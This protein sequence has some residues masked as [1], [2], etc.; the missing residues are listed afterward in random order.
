M[1][2][3]N[4]HHLLYFWTVAREG[5][6]ARASERLRLAQPTISGQ[7]R[8]LER[9]L[10]HKL[11]VKKGRGLALTEFGRMVYRHADEIFRLGGELMEA[12]KGRPSGQPLR[13]TVGIADVMPKLVTYRL[14]EPAIRLPE[15][16]RIVC[17]EDRPER[18]LADLAVHELDIVLADAPIPPSV[19]VRA[20]NHLLGECGVSVLATREI[21]VRH[22]KGFPKSLDGAP[23][24]LPLEGTALR[25]SLDQWLDAHEI[26]PRIIAECDDSALIKA[27]GQAG[28]GL[29]VA[30]DVIEEEVRRQYGVRV[31]GRVPEVRE[32]FYAI[33]VERRLKH[34]AVVAI[35]EAARSATFL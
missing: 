27:F 19:K 18:L 20:Y 12:V 9:S 15:P 3:L 25:R 16:V 29:F 6:V 2:W 8:A 22:S 24:L 14:L 11:F 17:R 13:L 1:D 7:I 4:Y 10:G 34:P 32:R 5:S 31:V 21:A 28:A 35:S 33:S 23:M 26:R 30:S